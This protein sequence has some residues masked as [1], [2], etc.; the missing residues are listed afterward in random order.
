LEKHGEGTAKKPAESDIWLIATGNV[1]VIVKESDSGA[2]GH[3]FSGTLEAGTTKKI[4]YGKPIQVFYDGGEF[5]M[6]KQ[7]DGEKLYLQPGRG[8]VA[9]R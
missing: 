4:S 8:A 1:N 6:I 7:A 3:I 2:D 9:L 5:L